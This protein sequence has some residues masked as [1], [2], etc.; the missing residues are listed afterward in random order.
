MS[1][2]LIS[3]SFC[4]YCNLACNASWWSSAL[5]RR[6]PRWPCLECA[7][8][9]SCP[10]HHH[11]GSSLYVGISTVVGIYSFLTLFH[12][13]RR[14]QPF[15]GIPHN[16]ERDSALSLNKLYLWDY[17]CIYA[18]AWRTLICIY[19]TKI[20]IKSCMW[21]QNRN[22][23]MLWTGW[24]VVQTWSCQEALLAS[25]NKWWELFPVEQWAVMVS[26][27]LPSDMLLLW[28]LI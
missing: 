18:L 5:V 27:G 10:D 11:L 22:P 8:A 3:S 1:Q 26:L 9:P 24:K 4:K 6:I 15:K 28:K 16:Y 25:S 20:Q 2:I 21:D 17:I 19:K 23:K 13:K 12:L 7:P 14:E